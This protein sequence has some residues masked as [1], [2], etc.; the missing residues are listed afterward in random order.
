[1][2]TKKPISTISYNSEGFLREKLDTWID[3]HL[4]QSY[5]YI[6]HKGEDGDKNHIHLRVE[7]N[8]SLDVM[9]LSE[10]LKEWQVGNDKPLGVRPWRPSKEEDWFLYAVHDSNYLK[11]KYQGGESHEKIPY[12]WQDIKAS[13]GYDVEVAYIR[14]LA[15]LRHTG[16]SLVSRLREGVHPVA[17]IE[18]GENIFNI[19]G[20]VR[21]MAPTETDR[22]QREKNELFA[23][24]CELRKNYDKL[25]DNLNGIVSA[26]LEWGFV[27]SQDKEG[28]FLLDE[29]QPLSL[30]HI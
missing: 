30:I 2:A 5:M 13:E 28:N 3:A 10:A 21:A 24:Y 11:Y 25:R 14:A 18:E 22:L 9:D 23:D 19:N 17:L 27:L 4:I 29:T 15:S 7:P 16:A 8:K 1:M 26:L 12:Q 6:C 20:I